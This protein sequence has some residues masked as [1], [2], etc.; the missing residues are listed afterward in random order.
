[1]DAVFLIAIWA[2][3]FGLALFIIMLVCLVILLV[4]AV[5]KEITKEGG[6]GP[7]G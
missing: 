7:Y 1:M 4:S 3:L 5:Y 6:D 2:G